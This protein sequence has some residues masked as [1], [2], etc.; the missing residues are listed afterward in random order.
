MEIKWLGH[1]C[2]RIKGK[3][4]TV[5]TDPFPPERGYSLGK[6]TADIITVSHEQPGHNYIEGVGGNPRAITGAGEYEIAD[7]I[8]IGVTTFKDK[9]DGKLVGKNTVYLMEIDEVSVCHLGDISHVLTDDQVEE[10]GKVDVLFLPV[11]GKTSI[12]ASM[13]AEIVRQLE[14]NAVI[15][16]HFRTQRGDS[17]LDPVDNF[18]KEM[19][20]SNIEP[21]PKLNISKASL[22]MNTQVFLLEC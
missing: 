16:M 15:P 5:I 11:G 9:V 22:P 6:P 1:S 18:F 10:L 19:G 20:L 4:T 2:F 8:I 12:D 17:E 13:A 7:V 21:Q 3:R 14:P